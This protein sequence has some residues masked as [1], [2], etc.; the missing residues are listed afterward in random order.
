MKLTKLKLTNIGLF[1][2]GTLIPQQINLIKGINCDNPKNSS[3]GCG[4]STLFKIALLF[5]L[6]GETCGRKL[7]RIIHSGAKTAEVE[8]EITH[9]SNIIRIIRKIPTKLQVFVN[10]I[11]REFNSSTIAQ[12]YLNEIFGDFTFFKKYCLVDTK[13]IN[14]LDSLDDSRSIVSFKKELMGFIDTEFAP[15][16]ESL[17][18]KKNDREL[19]SVDKRL[20]KFHL[21]KKRLEILENGLERIKEELNNVNRDREIQQQSINQLSGEITSSES[22]IEF[23]YNKESENLN[24]I[25]QCNGFVEDNKTIIEKLNNLPK[26][27]KIAVIDYD[28]DLSIAEKKSESLNQ[29]LKENEKKIDLVK[30]DIE[31][32]NFQIHSAENDLS[33]YNNDKVKL[34]KEIIGLD[35]VKIGT[36]CDKCGSLVSIEYRDSYRKD[37]TNEI[38]DII[39]KEILLKNSLIELQN[40]LTTKNNELKSLINRKSLVSDNIEVIKKDIKEL[41]NKKFAQAEAVKKQE[42]SATQITTDIEK[43]QNS[44]K[45]SEEQ[46][47]KYLN[48]NI[49]IK[50]EISELKITIE[51]NKTKLSEES[52][53]IDY[54]NDLYNGIQHKETRTKD[55]IMKLK[56]A[57]KFSDYKYTKED[58]RLYADSIKTL[59]AFSGYYIQEW[60]NNLSFIINDLLKDLNLS[61]ELTDEKE[62]LKIKDGEEEL[63]YADLSDGQRIFFSGIFKLAILLKKGESDG[64]IIMDDGLGCLDK[65]NFKNLIDICQNLPFQLFAV[66]QD[67]PIIEN[68][69]EFIIER[70]NGESKII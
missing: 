38:E 67:L 51:S 25:E 7:E 26:Q 65:I 41:N 32:I 66:F 21:S 1:K 62:F 29:E 63:T 30:K 49:E 8:L 19:Y 46:I 42:N 45:I 57:F 50:K 55:C 10:G 68:V 33:K 6:F 9:G 37:K 17:L 47:K 20:Y 44:I 53:C 40:S 27:E 39:K 70:K 61:I 59:D 28:K 18:G 16:R 48:H 69:N 43:H 11:D 15:H 24:N 64:I 3:N 60:M 58:I 12:N 52:N 22:K 13:S 4:K 5:G 34:N 36:K 2:E 23:L 56:E 31:K 35:N 54:Y 14:L